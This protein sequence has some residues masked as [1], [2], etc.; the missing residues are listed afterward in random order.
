VFWIAAH[1]CVTQAFLSHGLDEWRRLF[2]LTTPE[3]VVLAAVVIP[4]IHAG[5]GSGEDEGAG[6]GAE[7]DAVLPREKVF[8]FRL[9]G[10]DG[11]ALGRG[12][13]PPPPADDE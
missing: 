4:E 7:E 1:A 8:P 5:E 3:P 10:P 9:L 2:R 11:K 13:R 6:A 12:P